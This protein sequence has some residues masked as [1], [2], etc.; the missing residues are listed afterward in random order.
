M[1]TTTAASPATMIR[2]ALQPAYGVLGAISFC[3]L[4]NDMMQALLIS[5]YP[6]LKTGFDLSFGQIGVL[7]L[8]YQLTAS[9]LQPLIGAATDRRPMPYSLSM[10][11]VSTG[12]GLLLLAGAS[13]YPVLLAGAMFLGIGSSVF[14]PEASRIARL[15]SGGRHGLAQSVF[16]VGGNF[17][18]ALG[19][20]L[21]AFVV[22]PHGKGSLAW[23]CLAA[24]TAMTLLGVLGRWYQL[25]LA[26]RVSVQR[27]AA[28]ASVLP[29]RRVAWAI[30]I[31]LALMFSKFVYMASMGNYYVFYLMEHF[32]LTQ[33][34]A[35]VDLFV[36]LGAGVVGIL[37]GGPIGDRIGP[38]RV[39]WGSILGVLPF[40]LALPHAGL[41][42][43]VALSVVIGLVLSSAFS[44]IVVYAQELVP[45]R[46]GMISGLF[47]GLAFGV[48]G[49][50]A[51]AMGWL[52]DAT[53]VRTVFELCAFLPA[54][55]LL[56]GFLPRMSRG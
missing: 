51:A 43:T 41:N 40:T 38:R 17:G 10:G 6:I 29:A 55:G 28:P 32:G 3:H 25:R 46:V 35:Q 49:V 23:F 50:A 27:R 5:L 13:T 52:A 53:S 22:L 37:I 56:A 48:G 42:A 34:Q 44:A 12:S 2:P 1:S 7:S 18:Q 24:L 47:F 31:L 11:M 39:I 9:L 54:I 8:V 16:Q 14:H 20:L 45:G 4:L 33:A 26:T 36:F 19:P 30:G 15:A 21:M